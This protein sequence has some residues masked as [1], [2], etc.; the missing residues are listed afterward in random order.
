MAEIT[1]PHRDSAA[2]PLPPTC[3]ECG[4]PAGL[5]RREDFAWTPSWALACWLFGLLPGA[6]AVLATRRHVTIDLPVCDRHRERESGK[7]TAV[8]LALGIGL[9]AGIAGAALPSDPDGIGEVLFMGGVGLMI[10]AGLA[11]L[12]LGGRGVR[13]A[14]ISD[15]QVRLAGV[16]E[17]FAQAVVASPAEV[18]PPMVFGLQ[19]EKY[20]RGRI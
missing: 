17:E 4:A 5:I 20:M 19:T 2:D 6:L 12:I 9:V 16:S 14:W 18:A 7:P 1:V 13:V 15:H 10:L 8:W 3:V 11:A